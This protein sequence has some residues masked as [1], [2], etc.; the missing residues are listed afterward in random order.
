MRVGTIAASAVF[1]LTL[2]L[3]FGPA[4]AIEVETGQ[5]PKTVNDPLTT[6]GG[7]PNS[8]GVNP[9]HGPFCGLILEAEGVEC[10]RHADHPGDGVFPKGMNEGVN[11]GAWNAFFQSNENSVICGITDGAPGVLP[12][13]SDG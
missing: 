6:K 13:C 3:S 9:A 10:A 5:G 8:D 2:G 11:L 12:S 7:G 1:L 4:G